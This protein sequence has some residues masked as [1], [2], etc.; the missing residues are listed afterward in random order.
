V[1]AT[2]SGEHASVALE[3]LEQRDQVG[4]GVGQRTIDEPPT[5]VIQRNCV[6]G[7]AGDVDAAEHLELGGD[8]PVGRS[9][10]GHWDPLS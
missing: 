6:M 7:L 1:A 10:L 3:I 4:L 8:Q 5:V 9:R 2:S